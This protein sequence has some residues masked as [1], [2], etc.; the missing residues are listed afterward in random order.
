MKGTRAELRKQRRD[1][2]LEGKRD[3][4]RR[5]VL[6]L[7][8]ESKTRRVVPDEE[9]ALG[10]SIYFYFFFTRVG[11][12][13]GTT[14]IPWASLTANDLY[15]IKSK[16]WVAEQPWTALEQLARASTPGF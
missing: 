3:K 2:Q 7:I 11:F 14:L 9:V 15:F 1:S 5:M 8:P 4:V 12:Q 16:T 6:A 10:M 13:R